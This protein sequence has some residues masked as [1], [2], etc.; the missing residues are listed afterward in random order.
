M[1]NFQ[2]PDYLNGDHSFKMWFKIMWRNYYIQTFTAALFLA[3]MFI[4]FYREFN[5]GFVIGLSIPVLAMS[6]IAYKGFYQFWNDLK[7]NRSR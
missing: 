4:L 6:I 7:N 5:S 2:E 1:K 3:I